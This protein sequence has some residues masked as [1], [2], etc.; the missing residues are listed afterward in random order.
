MDLC[1]TLSDYVKCHSELLK[2]EVFISYHFPEVHNRGTH[3]D[4]D[5]H[6]QTHRQTQTD[7]DRHTDTQTDT[8]I[9]IDRHTDTQTDTQIDT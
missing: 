7:T 8:D 2:K 5:R 6:T 1:Q 9:H 3:T 4:T